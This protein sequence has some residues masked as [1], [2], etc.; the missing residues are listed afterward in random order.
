VVVPK[1][2]PLAKHKAPTL[3]QL[4]AYPIVTYVF[5]FSGPSSLME[6]FAQE[7]LVPDVAL[8]ARDADVI[9]TYVRLGLGIGI[10][11]SMAIDPQEDADL[12]QIDT[13]HLF[14]THTTWIG[15]RRGGLLRK[16]QLDFVQRFA[17]HLTRRVIEKAASATS[18]ADV[19]ELVKNLELPLR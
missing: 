6:I 13:S 7:G 1:G 17:P 10:V 2:H 14:P 12:V 4:A 15:F 18:Q 3:K 8:T 5:G 16:Y 9:K 19:D 11:A